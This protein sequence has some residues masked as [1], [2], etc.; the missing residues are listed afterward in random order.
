[1]R[2]S[3]FFRQ[4]DKTMRRMLFGYMLVL[5]ALL[6]FVIFAGLFLFG[7]Y[8]TAKEELKSTLSLQMEVFE[9]EIVSHHDNL[10][11]RNVRL[12]ENSSKAVDTYLKKSGLSFDSLENSRQ[13][14]ANVESELI[15]ILS[16]EILQTEC[17]GI[18]VLLDTTVNTSIPSARD[19]RSGVYL[20]K[21]SIGESDDTLLLYRGDAQLGKAK[22]IMPHRKW[23]LE[24]NKKFFPGYDD[25]MSKSG[26]IPLEK[27]YTTTNIATLLGTSEKV[28]LSAVP[29]K[30]SDGRIWGVCGFE[31]S[32]STFGFYH[33]QPSTLKHLVGMFSK[34]TGDTIDCEKSFA[35]GI[36]NGY[37]LAP[38]GI[39]TVEDFGEDLYLFTGTE[40]SYIGM[41]RDVSICRGKESDHTLCVMVPKYDY[42]KMFVQ[43]LMQLTIFIVLL[44][45]FALSCCG[46]FSKHYISP[47]T[48]RLNRLKNNDSAQHHP[49]E[50]SY[51]EIDDLFEFLAQKEKELT[52]EKT[53]ADKLSYHR[54]TEINPDDYEFFKDGIK[55]LTKTERNVFDLY[56]SGKSAK[57]ITEIAGIKERTLK[58][59]NSNIYSKL[60]VRNL[61][62]LMR[63]AALYEKEQDGKM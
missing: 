28:M 21:S 52:K 63:F 60:G 20:Q 53:R 26:D 46:F 61:K 48:A 29:I 15:D 13:H 3:G 18:Y 22:G 45:F 33:S 12:S 62:E 31:I 37:H 47:I 39:L 1:M 57:E 59:H 51:S 50:K 42:N 38:E 7:H 5:A 4:K 23:K 54:K 11:M 30:G 55:M 36:T 44:V 19:S 41:K 8:S 56:M 43:N 24:Y 10:A 49:D 34:K 40:A 32:S 35:S 16:K 17:S 14:L 9:R 27:S 58:F 2:L 6:L 25:I